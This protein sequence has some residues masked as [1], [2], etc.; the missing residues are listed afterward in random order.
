MG[1]SAG[2]PEMRCNDPM[3]V[4]GIDGAPTGFVRCESGA[5]HRPEQRTCA[6]N[7]PRS[8]DV[9]PP[10]DASTGGC[11]SDH[12]CADLPYGHCRLQYGMGVTLYGCAQ[13]CVSDAEC[14][15]TQLCLCG[16]PVGTCVPASCRTDAECGG[17]LCLSSGNPGPCGGMWHD[18]SCEQEGDQ[19]TSVR[20]CPAQQSC[21]RI[22][23]GPRECRLPGACGRPFLV[24]GKE[25]AAELV[26]SPRGWSASVEMGELALDPEL[27]ALLVG[28]FA[29]AG[30]M[31]HASVAAFARFALDLLAL[32]AP[33]NLVRDSQG[34]LGDEIEHAKLCFGLASAFAGRP[35]EPGPLPMDGVEIG[36]AFLDVVKTAIDEACIGETIAAAEA[37]EAAAHASRPAVRASLARI[38]DDERR[39]AE[40]GFR[41]LGWALERARPDERRAIASYFRERAEAALAECFT[42]VEPPRRAEELLREGVLSASLER[43]VRRA[44]LAEVV[45]PIARTLAAEA[46]ER[47]A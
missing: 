34:A 16:D 22:G 4:L 37:A 39:H 46:L 42:E 25:R 30:L 10:P 19:C 3:P 45:V 33:A 5:T 6:S 20:D 7:V 17:R 32:G 24:A 35:I 26:A 14:G 44:A 21:T 11:T 1:G 29:R 23:Q 18:F 2:A 43:R 40:L 47:A 28:H 8:G 15:A 13:G 38:A 12:D 9:A 31:E 27:R 41:F 36:G